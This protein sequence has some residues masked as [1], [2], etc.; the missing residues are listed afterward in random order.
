MARGACGEFGECP[1][2]WKRSHSSSASPTLPAPGSG[3]EILYEVLGAGLRFLPRHKMKPTTAAAATREPTA[4]PALAPGDRLVEAV[5]SETGELDELLLVE[6]AEADILPE[7][8]ALAEV[9]D[10]DVWHSL[11]T[12]RSIK[13]HKSSGTLTSGVIASAVAAAAAVEEVCRV[14][15][16]FC[17]GGLLTDG[18]IAGVSVVGVEVASAVVDDD[19]T[20]SQDDLAQLTA[21]PAS[22]EVQAALAQSA[23]P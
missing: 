3:G 21:A 9:D 18:V 2:W 6:V 22:A 23:T 8:A 4:M 12:K 5:A 13:D 17:A 1:G 7:L 15:G 19:S 11:V 14:V 16:V 20:D 10:D